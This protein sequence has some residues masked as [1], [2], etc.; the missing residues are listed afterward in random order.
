MAADEIL[1]DTLVDRVSFAVTNNAT[2]DNDLD[3]EIRWALNEKLLDLVTRSNHWGL[4]TDASFATVA[5]QSEYALADDFHELIDSSVVFTTN[6][7]RTLLYMP[8]TDFNDFWLQTRNSQARPTHYWVRTRSPA[9]GVATIKLWPT[10]VAVDTVAYRYRAVPTLIN[11]T[12]RGAGDV[13]DRRFPIEHV[14]TLIHGAVTHFPNYLNAQD[15]SFH[16]SLY[17]Q[18]VAKMKQKANPVTGQGYNRRAYVGNQGL[19]PRAWW[20]ANLSGPGG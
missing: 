17:E 3:V 20:G 8:E 19:A 1:V 11:T 16:T 15:L 2:C 7:K 6:D 12:V 10:P 9:T 13:L 5:S 4:R 18:G 14:P